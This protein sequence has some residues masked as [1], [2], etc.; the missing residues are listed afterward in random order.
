M[1]DGEPEPLGSFDDDALAG[2]LKRPQEPSRIG[3]ERPQLS[4][5]N[6]GD[7]PAGAADAPRDGR[8][9]SAPG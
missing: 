8:A 4:N 1:E 3:Q 6:H 9:S 5:V 7:R 2:V